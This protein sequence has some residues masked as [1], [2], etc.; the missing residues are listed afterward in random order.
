M[1]QLKR[2]E[3]DYQKE[4][5]VKVSDYCEFYDEID[6]EK[7]TYSE[8]VQ[9]TRYKLFSVLV[10]SGGSATSGHYYAFIRPNP[11]N[12][13]FYFFQLLEGDGQWYKF[14]DDIVDLAEPDEVFEANFG[15]THTEAR[16]NS[17]SLEIKS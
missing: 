6:L 7:Y 15:G 3:F 13:Y 16:L 14:N 9:E 10:H 2:F 12:Y 11:G 8:N 5:M 17:I 1:V 4:T